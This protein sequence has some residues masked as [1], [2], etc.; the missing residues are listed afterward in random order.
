MNLAV[1][2]GNSS[3]KL[4]LFKDNEIAALFRI[5]GAPGSKVIELTGTH[6][7]DA[8]IVSDVSPRKDENQSEIISLKIPVHFLSSE[9][10]FPFSINYKTPSSLGTDRLASVAG[11]YNMWKTH[12]VLIIDAGTALTYDFLSSAGEY[13][14]GNISPGLSMRFKALNRYTGRLPLIYPKADFKLLGDDTESAIRAGV[15]LGL[16]FEINEYIRTFDKRYKD[17]KV[18]M[19]GG[20]SEVL[21]GHIKFSFTFEPDLIVEGLNYLLSCNA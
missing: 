21:S 9:S 14:G 15:E 20:D 19:T 4:A 11:A 7:L 2:I 12:N 8:I 17:L 10:R 16:V 6:D 3:S 13:M 5:E 18:I 1:D